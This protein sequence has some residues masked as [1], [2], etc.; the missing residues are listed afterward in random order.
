MAPPAGQSLC[1]CAFTVGLALVP[2]VVT[3]QAPPLPPLPLH[4]YPEPARKAVTPL[5]AAA[6]ARPDDASAAGALGRALHAWD[7]LDDAHAAYRRAQALAP[8]GFD[9]IY[10]DAIVLYRLARYEEAA[11]QFRRGHA[12]S[13][14][15]LPARVKLADA[16]VRIG[17]L[18]ES[19][20][21]FEALQDSS[22]TRPFAE[23]GL[24]QI[25]AAA[26][27]HATAAG[28]FER[29]IAL[30]PQWGEAHYALAIS[31]QRLGREEE[32]DRAM[33][34]RLR[35]GA[36]GPGL[37]DPVLASIS[38]IRAD[39]VA[40]LERG[41]ELDRAGD[42]NGAIAAHEAAVS[43]D[44]SFAQA[45]LNLILL[46]GR[47]QNWQQV[48]EHYRH[49]IALGFSLAD[50]NYNYGYAQ[51]LQGHWDLAEA[52][53]R[54]AIDA[55]PQHFAAHLNLGRALERR[56]DVKAAADEF[57]RAAELEPT[58]RVARFLLGRALVAVGRPLEA[59]ADLEKI[60]EPRDERTPGY[61]HVLAIAHAEAGNTREALARATAARELAAS[62]DQSELVE[63]IDRTIA[64]VKG[65]VR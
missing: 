10:L 38:R 59:I 16:L 64:A 55:S 60:L 18:D 26:G 30:F 61:L 6:V 56:K 37:E 62:Y 17:R 39:A 42:I 13:P 58:S 4:A 49:A 46:Y 12:L 44:P 31:Y 21:L 63:A 32:A 22:L 36:L 57:R 8:Q 40:H 47:T 5:Y 14:G 9:W 48:E 7:Q 53:Y 25:A 33:R 51:Q 52:A 19:K 50:V 2:A 35:F 11:A 3:A 41:V 45:H 15:Y 43:E 24:G 65:S 29:A 28:H 1:L 27:Q 54:R 23:F 34:E 20:P